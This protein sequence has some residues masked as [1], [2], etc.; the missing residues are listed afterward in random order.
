M[1]Q[2]MAPYLRRSWMA[3]WKKHSPNS[4]FFQ[5]CTCV[6]LSLFIINRLSFI[7][8]CLFICHFGLGPRLS[9][10]ST[11]RTAASSRGAPARFRLVYRYLLFIVFLIIMYYRYH[12]LLSSL[13]I[14]I[15][16]SSCVVHSFLFIIY[17]F[18]L[19]P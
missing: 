2:P 12:Y 17:R 9:K 16:R 4:S 15:Y 11:A 1:F 19:G 10:R 3:A 5:G 13:S 8:C 7:P 18:G 14:V 6:V